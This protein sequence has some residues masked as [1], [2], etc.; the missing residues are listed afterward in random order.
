[1]NYLL[2]SEEEFLLTEE[3]SKIIKKNKI[4]EL[5]VNRYDLEI[6]SLKTIIDDCQTISFF[7]DKKVIIINNCNYFNRVKNN[8]DDIE[9]LS[10][11]LEHANPNTIL[12]IL[13]HSSSVDNT[14][15]ITKKMKQFGNILALSSSNVNGL[16]K[17]MFDDFKIS[18][19]NISLLIER[20]GTDIAILAQEVDKLK[21]YKYSEKEITKKDILNCATYNIDTDIFKFIDNIITKNKESALST[22]YELLKNNEEPIKIIALLASKFRLMYQTSFLSK[23]GL[24]NN[25]ISNILGV[26]AYPVK[27]AIQAGMRYHEKILLSFLRKLADLDND[28]KTGTINAELG[29]ELFI[30]KV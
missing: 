30:L 5:S 6:D 29:L 26:H 18:N 8:N 9:L 21:C 23:K 10:E 20:V 22:Y 15:K 27:L 2:Y 4:E 1:M 24:N 7:E 13:N 14:K 3:V 17:E 12:I 11:Y 28:I 19:D 25:E 16:V